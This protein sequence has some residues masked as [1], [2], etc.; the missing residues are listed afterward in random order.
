MGRPAHPTRVTPQGNSRVFPAWSRTRQKP[1]RRR[2][3][4]FFPARSLCRR[5]SSLSVPVQKRV[6]ALGAPHHITQRG[7]SQQNVFLHD[8]LRRVYLE[9]VRY[10]RSFAAR[11]R[12]GE[13]TSGRGTAVP[14]RRWLRM[15]RFP[16]LPAFVHTTSDSSRNSSCH[17]L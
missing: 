13:R 10:F 8:D 2:P 1:R 15:V 9:L 7:N 11:S 14:L 12:G 4:P 17:L 6:V 5:T 16:D 3:F